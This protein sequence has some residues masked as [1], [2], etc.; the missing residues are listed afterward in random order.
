MSRENPWRRYLLS[1]G[2]FYAQ[3]ISDLKDIL[4]I[5]QNLD[6]SGLNW[7]PL[8]SFG[9]TE[10]AFEKARE[11][12]NDNVARIFLHPTVIKRHPKIVKYYRHIA[13]LSRKPLSR[14]IG[15]WWQKSEENNIPLTQ[16]QAEE[17]V[18]NVNVFISRQIQVFSSISD[19]EAT[20]LVSA[21]SQIE[22]Q[23]KNAIGI[24]AEH[25]TAVMIVKH[26]Q[27]KGYILESQDVENLAKKGSKIAINNVT[28]EFGDDPDIH[29]YKST[30][31]GDILESLCAIEVK[32]GTDP[33]G[34]LER[35][36]ASLK[37]HRSIKAKWKD[38]T[39]VLLAACITATVERRQE[40]DQIVDELFD[41]SLVLIPGNEERKNFLD[42]INGFIPPPS[43]RQT[44]LRS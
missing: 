31:A 9:I 15:S 30:S 24:G 7:Q 1:R 4:T 38:T 13:K 17:F 18:K 42:F 43:T 6:S 33:A 22:G 28:I 44:L 23:W 37:S 40:R 29:I 8:S 34:A 19:V 39:T 27:E 14:I 20:F 3:A 21:G 5:V 32:G 35:Y 2:S 26:L 41:L 36:G 10:K 11:L 25:S 12:T 16:T